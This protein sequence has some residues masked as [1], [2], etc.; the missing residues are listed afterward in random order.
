MDERVAVVT[1]AAAGMGKA[2]VGGLVGAGF[3]VFALDRDET[4]LATLGET[5]AGA[6]PPV[7]TVAADVTD[8]AGV[9][10]AFQGIIDAAG[11]VDVLVNNAGAAVA[12]KSFAETTLADWDADLRLNLTGQF[13]A[14]RAVLPSM[15]AAGAGSIINIATT[16]V[17][18]GITAQLHRTGANFVPYVAAK[19]GVVA[20]TRALAREVGDAGV[21][22]NAV[23]PGFTP[24]PRVQA[25]FPQ[26]AIDR[27]V[28]DLAIKRVQAPH[29]A[30]GA[31][32]FLASEGAG[33]ITGQVIRVDGGGS[34]G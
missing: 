18:T 9:A 4:G 32:L 19:G 7:R 23:A 26:E 34:M 11:R 21:R 14:V 10:A 2:Y 8:E 17:F 33:F 30:V 12:A 3:N 27:M 31:V 25:I 13:L 24:T 16:S 28:D 22:V 6:T 5:F 1:G 20:M 15:V 29:D